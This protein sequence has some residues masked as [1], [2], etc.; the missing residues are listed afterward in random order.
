MKSS[1]ALTARVYTA[2]SA[3]VDCVPEEDRLEFAK[4]LATAARA[5]V[6][7]LTQAKGGMSIEPIP[8]PRGPLPR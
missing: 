8:A 7:Y 6:I 2:V 3:L 4:L 5:R 1:S